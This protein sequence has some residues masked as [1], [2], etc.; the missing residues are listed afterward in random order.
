MTTSIFG[1]EYAFDKVCPYRKPTLGYKGDFTHLKVYIEE[2]KSGCIQMKFI[3]LGSALEQ[4]FYVL[5]YD[6]EKLYEKRMSLTAS[7]RRNMN[8]DEFIIEIL[9]EEIGM[10]Y[11]SHGDVLTLFARNG[12]EISLL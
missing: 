8:K 4:N 10:N 9:V 12:S 11:V 5:E 1:W 3:P 2:S 7:E 6:E